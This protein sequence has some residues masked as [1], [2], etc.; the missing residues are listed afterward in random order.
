MPE[1]SKLD[2]KIA[3]EGK[4]Q[5]VRNALAVLTTTPLSE[6]SSKA[7]LISSTPMKHS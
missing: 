5:N 6:P 4:L 3:I 2:A 1:L 7:R